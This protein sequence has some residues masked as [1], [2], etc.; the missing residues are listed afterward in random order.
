MGCLIQEL[1]IPFV[2]DSPWA[3]ILIY[4][5]HRKPIGTIYH[6]FWTNKFIFITN[7]DDFRLLSPKIVSI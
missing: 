2:Y 5:R 7:S 6:V 1:L 3:A 4:G